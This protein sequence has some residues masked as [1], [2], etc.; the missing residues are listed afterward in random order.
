MDIFNLA[1][2]QVAR[3]GKLNKK[4]DLILMLDRAVAIRNYIHNSNRVN[5]KKDSNSLTKIS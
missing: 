3:E 2:K 1:L 4:G 5:N